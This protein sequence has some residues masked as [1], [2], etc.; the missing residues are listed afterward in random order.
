[1]N[2][3]TWVDVSAPYLKPRAAGET[4]AWA[5]ESARQGRLGTQQLREVAEVVAP[6]D[7]AEALGI[8]RGERVV[9]RRRT[10]LLDHEPFELTDSYYPLSIA[11]GTPLAEPRKVRGGAPTVLAEIGKQ[12][13]RVHEHVS[14]RPPTD[15]ERD[16]L[17]L[18]DQWVLVLFRT[19]MA[20]DGAPV[21][22]SV[23]TMVPTGRRLSYELSL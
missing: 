19:V 12:P 13:S 23:M 21:E 5:D 2:E 1:M 8:E 10:M 22:V 20:E 16:L 11:T 6:D 14:T 4:D 18:G 15:L 3:R 7:V 17:G 9:V